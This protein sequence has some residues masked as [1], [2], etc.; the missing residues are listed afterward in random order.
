MLCCCVFAAGI[1][2]LAGELGSSSGS[3]DLNRSA[4]QA[5][6]EGDG[7]GA[8]G[9]RASEVV[10]GARSSLTAASLIDAI[11]LD[12]IKRTDPDDLGPSLLF[13]SIPFPSVVFTWRV[14]T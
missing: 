2:E 3:L 9:R 1:R 11:I 4:S 12:Q 14:H 6:M 5:H 13:P 10:R 8:A 7:E